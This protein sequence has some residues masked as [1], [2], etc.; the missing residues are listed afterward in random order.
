VTR[1]NSDFVVSRK[2]PASANFNVTAALDEDYGI[3]SE[4][5][6]RVKVNVT[7]NPAT[8]EKISVVALQTTKKNGEDVTS[9]Y[10]TVYRNDLKDFRI[11][12]RISEANLANYA[13]SD[14]VQVNTNDGKYM[15]AQKHDYHYRQ[16][17]AALDP[18][19]GIPNQKCWLDQEEDNM[20]ESIDIYK[21]YDKDASAAAKKDVNPLNLNEYVMTHMLPQWGCRVIDMDLYGLHFEFDNLNYV[22]NNTHSN[23]SENEYI[24]LKDGVV[25]VKDK[26]ISSAI[27]RVPIIRVR[28]VHGKNTVKVAYIKLKIVEPIESRPAPIFLTLNMHDINFQCK[29]AEKESNYIDMSTDIYKKMNMSKRQFHEVYDFNGVLSKADYQ[30]IVNYTGKDIYLKNVAQLVRTN[31]GKYNY[32]D[33]PPTAADASKANPVVYKFVDEHQIADDHT[34]EGTYIPF[35]GLTSLQMWTFKGKDVYAIYTYKHKTNGP[36]V[37]VVM[38]MH[39]N[40]LETPKMPQTTKI[41]NYWTK[42]MDETWYSVRVPNV[43]QD[44]PNTCIFESDLNSPFRTDKVH[45]T[46]L[47]AKFTTQFPAGATAK[48]GYRF[49]YGDDINGK[50]LA[51]NVTVAGATY[52]FKPVDATKNG[53]RYSLLT[54][55]APGST[56]YKAVALITNDVKKEQDKHEFYYSIVLFKNN[57]ALPAVPE[58]NGIKVDSDLGK[59]LLNTCLFKVQIALTAYMCDND[60]WKLNV[61]FPNTNT[62]YYVARLLRPV[63]FENITDKYFQDAVDFGQ[64][65]S[66]IDL[67][68]II[69]PHDWRDAIKSLT[70]MEGATFDKNIGNLELTNNRSFAQ[71]PNYWLYYGLPTTFKLYREAFKVSDVTNDNVRI[72]FTGT[73]NSFEKLPS[74]VYVK[75]MRRGTPEYLANFVDGDIDINSWGILTY[76]ANDVVL[77]QDALLEVTFKIQYGW[78]ELPL[79]VYIPVKKTPDVLA[80]RR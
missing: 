51:A 74:T 25:T 50:P 11:A 19:A 38:N 71:Y 55:K 22:I 1:A 60:L 62:D 31:L 26:Y 28:L 36:T 35:W 73:G 8:G 79:V 32:I 15:K 4:G 68:N 20:V 39:I 80:P 47:M 7:G 61:M 49:Y 69:K 75:S 2:A 9:D 56:E 70:T 33:N 45:S 76:R 78:G 66:Y 59:K 67:W 63:F 42:N 58:Y 12:A 30:T 3:D 10:A 65:G 72:D 21:F 23:T 29:D 43:N 46:N 40:P 54:V 53:I 18:Q 13:Q 57:V 48:F 77:K 64:P 5:L 16:F 14:R 24:N 41:E 6:I 17:I 44:D 52:S 37:Y 27:N 34:E